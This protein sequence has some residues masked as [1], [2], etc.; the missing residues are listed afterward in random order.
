MLLE[1]MGRAPNGGL[2]G[3]TESIKNRNEVLTIFHD[4]DLINGP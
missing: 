1:L 3:G 4:Y 2:N